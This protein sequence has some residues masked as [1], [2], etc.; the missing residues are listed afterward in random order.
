[1]PNGTTSFGPFVETYSKQVRSLIDLCKVYIDFYAMNLVSVTP[2]MFNYDDQVEQ[3]NKLT[4]VTVF[5]SLLIYP[6]NVCW[7][8]TSLNVRMLHRGTCSCNYFWRL[9]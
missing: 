9:F 5:M 8:P 4:A 7:F 2:I 6:F 1:M 3:L